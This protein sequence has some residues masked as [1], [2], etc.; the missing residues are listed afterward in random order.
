MFLIFH[1]K[2]FFYTFASAK[3]VRTRCTST[4]EP[5]AIFENNRPLALYY[6]KSNFIQK[7]PSFG[8]IPMEKVFAVVWAKRNFWCEA[9][10]RRKSKLKVMKGYFWSMEAQGCLK[11]LLCKYTSQG[12]SRAPILHPKLT[13][14][15]KF[16]THIGKQMSAS[17]TQKSN[18][19]KMVHFCTHTKKRN[20]S[21]ISHLLYKSVELKTM[22]WNSN[23]SLTLL[24]TQ[25]LS[26]HAAPHAT[27]SRNGY[28]PLSP[29]QHLK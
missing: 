8:K 26:L 7:T 2:S 5:K 17:S 6:T 25:S 19:L 18:V 21:W 20:F 9:L 23:V 24:Q 27:C 29:I 4:G 16:T 28:S 11:M 1:P 14:R 22:L 13:Y 15:S 10:Q 12:C 3:Q